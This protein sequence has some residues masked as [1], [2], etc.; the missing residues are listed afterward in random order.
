MT[1]VDTKWPFKR[2]SA[3]ADMDRALPD[4]RRNPSRGGMANDQRTGLVLPWQQRSLS[5]RT[6]L[7][8][9]FNSATHIIRSN[10][11]TATAQFSRE[12]TRLHDVSRGEILT[13]VRQQ[14]H[15]EIESTKERLILQITFQFYYILL[16]NFEIICCYLARLVN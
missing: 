1:N 16:K 4:G 11:K 12:D 3:L 13:C 9:S 2:D 5:S 10:S 7:H 6:L 8:P 15:E 14:L